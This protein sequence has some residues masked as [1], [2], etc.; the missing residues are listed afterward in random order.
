LSQPALAVR[1]V[2]EVVDRILAVFALRSERWKADCN[3][4]LGQT[5][6]AD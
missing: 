2:E 5:R 1:V 4:E 3:Q 6:E